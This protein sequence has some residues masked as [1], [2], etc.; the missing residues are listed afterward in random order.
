MREMGG[1]P[2][3]PPSSLPSG[4]TILARATLARPRLIDRERATLEL[5]PVQCLDGPV[6]IRVVRH[7]DKAEALG[8]TG[9]PVHDDRGFFYATI[10]FEHVR[11][12]LG[13]DAVRHIADVYLQVFDLR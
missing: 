11:E 7:V 2:P 10:L 4:R 1:A 6:G 5:R 13:R 9:L 8:A 12:I 3:D